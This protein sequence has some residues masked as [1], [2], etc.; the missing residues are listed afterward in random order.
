MPEKRKEPP[1]HSSGE[2]MAGSEERESKK[3]KGAGMLAKMGWT[4]GAGLGAEGG[5]RTEAIATEVY[6]P[7]V[8][9][10]AEGGKLGDASEEAARNTRGDFKAFVEK[11]RDRARERFERM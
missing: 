10:G 1:L 7:G 8:G 6:A 5:G 4:A 11:T 3:S 2:R 9:L